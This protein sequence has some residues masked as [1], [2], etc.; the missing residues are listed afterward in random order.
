[1]ICR[2]HT[3]RSI[4]VSGLLLLMILS[5]SVALPGAAPLAAQ[6]GGSYDLTWWTVDGGAGQVT[7][8][9]YTLTGTAG[10][11]DT[12]ALSA[13][14]YTLL[15]GFWGGGARQLRIYLPLV[16]RSHVP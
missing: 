8:G 14:G 6:T 4:A 13:G 7:A 11:H 3:I 1:M 10:Q 12:G 16:L 2:K 5:L 15:A 9:G